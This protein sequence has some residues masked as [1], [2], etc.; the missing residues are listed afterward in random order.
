MFYIADS[1][2]CSQQYKEGSFLLFHGNISYVNALQS[3][4]ARIVHRV[5]SILNRGRGYAVT[6]LVEALCYKPEGRGFDFCG[7]SLT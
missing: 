6:Y 1:S 3:R 4:N 5:F 2:I 7:F